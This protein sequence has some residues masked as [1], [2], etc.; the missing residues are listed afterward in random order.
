MY[1]MSTIRYVLRTDKANQDGISPIQLIYQVS[2]DRKYFTTDLKI[3]E[4]NWNAGDQ[5]AIYLTKAEAKKLLPG[6]HY[7]LLPS[8]KDIESLNNSLRSL[9]NKVG[10]IEKRFELNGIVYS[11]KMVVDELK[12]TKK[13]TTKKEAPANEVI[14]F[15]TKYIEDHKLSREPGS[16]AVYRALKQHLLDFATEKRVKIG[17]ADIDLPFFMAFQNFLIGS[18]SKRAPKGL[19]NVT[20]AKQLST[21][22]TFLNY[23]RVQGIAV[24]DS[25]KDFKIKKERLEVI[26]LTNDEFETLY[27]LDLSKNIRLA[28]VRDVFCFSCATGLRYSDLAQLKREHIKGDEIRLIVKKTKDPLV[29]PLNPYSHNIL[30]KYSDFPR[31][32]PVISNQKMNE[33]VK[34]L[35]KLAEIDDPVQIVRF[36][37]AKREE[38]SYPK[39][40]LIS[41][42]TGRKTFCTLSLEKGMSA[43]EVM[44]ISGHRDYAS[45]SRY[46]RITEQRSKIVMNK[47]WGKPKSHLQAV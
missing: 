37:G 14:D 47:A 1:A 6:V 41:V 34:E 17:F 16:L 10:D 35:C 15:V 5:K 20:I 19:G 18:K 36:R 3:R 27:K 31:P 24:P 23:A 43:E 21:L 44:K 30:L 22:K 45:F 29:I 26:A 25:Y 40:E 12:A 39:Y 32:L 8:N 42:H 11:C 9:A 4:Q 13:A 28:Q 7:D 46:V 38:K 2:G 33:Y